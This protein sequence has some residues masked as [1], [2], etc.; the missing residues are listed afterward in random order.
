MTER[1][2][3]KGASKMIENQLGENYEDIIEL[4]FGITLEQFIE[5]FVERDEDGC[6]YS[7]I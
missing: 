2:D 1:I 6:Y 5:W 4:E 3:Y 7:N